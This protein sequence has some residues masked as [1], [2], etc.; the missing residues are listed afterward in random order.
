MRDFMTEKI[1]YMK[2]DTLDK[3]LDEY[4]PTAIKF[5][6]RGEP[7][8]H[9]RICALIERAKKRGVQQTLLNTNGLLLLPE[10]T[11]NLYGAGLDKL[12]IS[13]D[14][15]SKKVYESIRQG[16]DFEVFFKNVVRASYVFHEKLRIQMCPQPQNIH[17]LKDGSWVKLYYPYSHDLRVGHLHD[18][19]GKRG[20]GTKIPKKC[21]SPWQRLVVAWNGDIYPCPSDY[22]GYMNLGNVNNTSI[23][24]AWHSPRMNAL[25]HIMARYGRKEHAL[26]KNCSSYC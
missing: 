25:R 9:K 8:L 2:L 19:Q 1:G 22:L 23:Y 15:A 17:E 11:N 5:N 12:I 6:W 13:A 21:T 3:I 20:Y 14:G 18:P 24:D 26:C 7:L 10:L 4:T 16:G